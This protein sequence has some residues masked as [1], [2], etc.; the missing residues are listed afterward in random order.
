MELY[1]VKELIDLAEIYI[2]KGYK[3]IDALKKAE[4]ELRNNKN[5]DSIWGIKNDYRF[6]KYTR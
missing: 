2:A 3:T 5:I 1:R 6:K 4:E